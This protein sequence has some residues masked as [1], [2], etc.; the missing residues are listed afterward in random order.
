MAQHRLS[1]ERPHDRPRICETGGLDH[2]APE[3]WNL[4]T[5]ASAKEA[6]DSLAQIIAGRT[7]KAATREHDGRFI[8]ALEKVMIKRDLAKLV[9]EHNGVRK[10]R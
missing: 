2:H 4:A 5:L 9:D 10:G 1:H 7:T 6:S 8:D 3:A